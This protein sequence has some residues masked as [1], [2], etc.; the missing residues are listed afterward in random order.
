MATTYLGFQVV[1][2]VNPNGSVTYDVY[3]DRAGL[4]G[5]FQIHLGSFLS[6]SEAEAQI[7]NNSTGASA[8]NYDASG[9]KQT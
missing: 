2:K 7:A 9:K 1:K 6:E 3:G 5:T 4:F 8:V